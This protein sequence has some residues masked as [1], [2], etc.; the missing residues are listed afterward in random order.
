M[1]Y[2]DV[3][4]IE[5]RYNQY[6]FKG[7]KRNADCKKQ[8]VAVCGQ[9]LLGRFH[10]PYEAGQAYAWEAQ[11]AVARLRE[12]MQSDKQQKLDFNKTVD[13]D[14]TKIVEERFLAL[15]KNNQEIN[16]STREVID[17]VFDLRPS[18]RRQMLKEN[19]RIPFN[20]KGYSYGMLDM[21][22]KRWASQ[23]SGVGMSKNRGINYYYWHE[24]N[25]DRALTLIGNE[26]GEFNSS[27]SS[28]EELQ[29]CIK[30]HYAGGDFGFKVSLEENKVVGFKVGL[31]SFNWE[32]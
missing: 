27:P 18:Q 13:T 12:H 17:E 23:N 25:E 29:D 5:S 24:T 9:R 32:A 30:V 10:T 16:F 2:K 22:F 31:K 4:P 26:Y 8:Y 3:K 6:G 11:N 1:K 20:G 28:I 19:N 7:V 15:L 21:L 14:P